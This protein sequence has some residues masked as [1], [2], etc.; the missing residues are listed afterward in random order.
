MS[1]PCEVKGNDGAYHCPYT[2]KEKKYESELC[3]TMC[4]VDIEK[5]PLADDEDDD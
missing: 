5:D 1:T 2:E 3:R 4:D